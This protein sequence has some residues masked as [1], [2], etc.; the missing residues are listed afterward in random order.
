VADALELSRSTLGTIRGNLL[1][2]FIYNGAAIPLAAAG[3]LNPML[4]GAAMAFSSI[5][6]VLNSLKLNA[7]GRLRSRGRKT[8]GQQK[9]DS[10]KDAS[11]DS[12]A[13]LLTASA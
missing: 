5:F 12:A 1:W 6:V 13:F 7:F 10:K 4:A 2:A 9:K 3:L 11:D 8:D